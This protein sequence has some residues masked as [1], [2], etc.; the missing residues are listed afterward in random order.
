MVVSSGGFR[1]ILSRLRTSCGA[2]DA[3]PLP[4]PKTRPRRS[5]AVQLHVRPD[6]PDCLHT[7]DSLCNTSGKQRRP[8]EVVLD[9]QLLQR[10]DNEVLRNWQYSLCT[11]RARYRFAKGSIG[12]HSISRRDGWM[13]CSLATGFPDSRSIPLS[14]DPATD[15]GGLWPRSLNGRRI[16]P[17]AVADKGF[18]GKPGD[19][20]IASMASG[21]SAMCKPSMMPVP[22]PG[23]FPG[24]AWANCKFGF[25]RVFG[26][27]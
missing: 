14:L 3:V 6:A 13:L 11:C 21:T 24:M 8:I 9:D 15:R 18:G 2:M 27:R 23:L 20:R 16:R 25:M 12:S 10:T 5:R 26:S 1:A 19:F 22:R 4:L 17:R 7:F